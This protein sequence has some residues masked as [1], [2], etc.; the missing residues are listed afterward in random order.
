MSKEDYDSFGK[1]LQLKIRT[2]IGSKFQAH[3]RLLN[4]FNLSNQTIAY[5]TAYVIIINIFGFFNFGNPFT[6]SPQIISFTTT[7][8]SILLF[9][10]CL[11]ESSKEY[12][13]K[14]ERSHDCAKELNS[15][16]LD[17]KSILHSKT[18]S[19]AEKEKLYLEIKNRYMLV[20]DKY[21]NHSDV[22]FNKYRAL[23]ESESKLTTLEKA[24]YHLQY[25]FA[26][27]FLYHFLIASPPII[28]FLV[29]WEK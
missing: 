10:F 15:V 12:N 26:S 24:R 29:I 14:A 28:L 11:I 22:D 4:R 3:N 20:L 27:G 17:L 13:L 21:D 8:I 23:Y 7:S 25:Y 5:L 16:Y 1:E 18:I 9:S 2:T 19:D 6:I